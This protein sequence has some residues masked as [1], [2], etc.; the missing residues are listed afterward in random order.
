MSY[1][2]FEKWPVVSGQWTVVSKELRKLI[3]DH[4]PLTTA[5]TAI[6]LSN[7][8]SKR[9]GYSRASNIPGVTAPK[10][11]G[12]GILAL[13]SM[14]RER[15]RRSRCVKS[16]VPSDLVRSISVDN[17][18]IRLLDTTRHPTSGRAAYCGRRVRRVMLWLY[19]SNCESRF[20]SEPE[21]IATGF[22]SPKIYL[23]P[24]K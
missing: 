5:F 24:S 21:A 8:E 1:I 20:L 22:L 7:I 23:A 19:V 14:F 18:Q 16:S 12:Q 11:R 13:L 17:P 15:E 6:Q 10:K 3:T 9:S 4:R 2:F